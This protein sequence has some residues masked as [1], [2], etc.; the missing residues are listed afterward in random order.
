MVRENAQPTTF[1]SV[2]SPAPHDL[3]QVEVG[4]SKQPVFLPQTKVMRW[5]NE[6]NVSFRLIQAEVA[7][8]VTEADDVVRWVGARTEAHFYS[9]PNSDLHPEGA[10]EIEIIL[11]TPPATNKVQFTVAA[12]G[13]VFWKQPE[14][15]APDQEEDDLPENV[16][17]SYAVYLAEPKIN[18]L[19]GTLYRAGKMGHIY[20]PQMIDANG[21][22][23][24]GDLD[25]QAPRGAALGLLTVT[26]P[27]EFLDKAAYPIRH[28]A[29][30]TF[31]NTTLGAS[32]SASPGGPIQYGPEPVFAGG[33]GTGVSMSFGG[34][35]RGA[36]GGHVKMATYDD[37]NPTS[38]ITDATTDE[39]AITGLATD[40]FK[41]WDAAFTVAPTFAAVNYRLFIS[42]DTP[43]VV[44]VKFDSTG[45]NYRSFGAAY[46][47]W[48]TPVTHNDSGAARQHS[49]YT[50]YTAAASGQPASKRWGGVQF[51]GI[52]ARG[53]W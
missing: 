52:G 23:A 1:T 31:G 41:Y 35:S 49:V 18:I 39:V 46:G 42:V 24:W 21:V 20:R 47:V 43:S 14:A 7:P 6:A 8:V 26:I 34:R 53:V 51:S 44:T 32:S 3:I 13:V 37:A 45:S 2:V 16:R 25:I 11:L 30:L 10:Q 50:T 19:G 48:T 5:G 38:L 15:L 22:T 9:L 33:V 28:A 36:G 17:G 29:G 27:R 40:P 12:K 4:D